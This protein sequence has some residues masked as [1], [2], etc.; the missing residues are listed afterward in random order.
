MKIFISILLFSLSLTLAQ[1]NDIAVI[2]NPE[3]GPQGNAMNLLEVVEEINKQQNISFV[4]VIGNITANGKFDEFVWAQEILDGLSVPYYVLGGEKDYL[5][6]E[7]KGSEITLLWGDDKFFHS[8]NNYALVCL[9]SFLPEYPSKKYFGAETLS[10]LEENLSSSKTSELITFSYHPIQI[11]ENASQILKQLTQKK[12]FSFIG[13]EDKPNMSNSI[14]E[15]LYLNR[16]DGWG[17]LLVSTN[18]DSIYIKK[19][20]SDEIKKKVIHEVLRTAFTKP[21]IVANNEQ[22]SFISSG[23]KLWSVGVNRTKVTSSVTDAEKIFSVFKNGLVL[24]M[25]KQGKE[26]WRFETNEKLINPP[27]LEKDLLV[28]TSDDGDIITINVNTGNPHQ[29]IGIGERI[30]TGVSVIDIEEGRT[31][32]KAVVIGTEFGS[33]L[34]YDLYS[35][36]PIWTQQVAGMGESLQLVSNIVSSNNKIFLQDNS[37]TLYCFYA[38]NG[39]LIWQIEASISGWEA[40]SGSL[41]PSRQN[42]GVINNEIFI[43]DAAGNLFCVDALLGI[44]KWNIKNLDATSLITLNKQN[45]LILPTTKNKIAVVSTKIGKVTTEIELPLELKNEFITDLV[46]ISDKIL[47]GF[48]N[49]WVYKIKLKQKVEKFFRG[50]LAPVISLTNID[51]NCLVTDYDGRFTLLKLTP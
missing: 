36:D 47:V 45:E 25:D 39:M 23:S 13:K 41:V 18:R 21:L 49:G 50:G 19:I 8:E 16:K 51:G 11:A 5:L 32:A 1:S 27:V 24:C 20:L 9:N 22:T 10:W 42:L 17:Y 35:L 30:T 33:L 34:C 31:L 43:V 7:G 4:V 26:K 3:V 2:T 12:I 37:G 48:S 38:A 44:V 40:G 15:G 46:V 6:S 29:I 14:F 28:V